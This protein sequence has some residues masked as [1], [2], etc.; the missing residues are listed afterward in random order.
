MKPLHF[1]GKVPQVSTLK[2]SCSHAGFTDKY[3]AVRPNGKQTEVAINGKSP[4]NPCHLRNIF[5]VLKYIR[6]VFL[7]WE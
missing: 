1:C 7:G 2:H 3:S 6:S 4:K 5:L